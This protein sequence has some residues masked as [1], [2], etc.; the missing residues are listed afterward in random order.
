MS[1]IDTKQVNMILK[2]HTI[3]TITLNF[4]LLLKQNLQT[5]KEDIEVSILMLVQLILCNM[6][7]YI[8]ILVTVIFSICF[9][10]CKSAR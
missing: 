5:L 9:S 6:F 10:V 2:H 8:L 4:D 7:F 3:C 1:N